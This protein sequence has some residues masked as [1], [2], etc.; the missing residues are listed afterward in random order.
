MHPN[1]DQPARRPIPAVAA[2]MIREGKLL[3]IRR[4]VEPSMGKWS[5]PGGSIEWGE[6]MME[7][8]KR[9][10][11][12]ETGLEVEVGRIAGVFDL[13]IRDEESGPA[14]HYV[15][16]DLFAS[17][18][19]GTLTPGDDA[20]EARWVPIEDLGSYELSPFLLSR[21]KQMRVVT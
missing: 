10:V 7:A 4:G 14:F 21:L 15:I 17:P 8:V 19:G 16:I 12:E 5:I 20:V 6:P 11:R 9:E 3:L 18:V 13:I 2:V 1:T